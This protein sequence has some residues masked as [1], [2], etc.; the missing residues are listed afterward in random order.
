M[1][2][3]V[4]AH[5]RRFGGRRQAPSPSSCRK[6]I[7]ATPNGAP[8][9]LAAGARTIGPN[10]EGLII[11]VLANRPHPEQGFR[12]CLGIL[13]LHRGIEVERAAREMLENVGAGH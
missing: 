3:R 11:T 10:T 2:K 9:A 12:T 4:A 6:P 13:R 7:A 1:G 5:Q 8:S